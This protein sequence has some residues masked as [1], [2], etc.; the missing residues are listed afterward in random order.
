MLCVSDD[1]AAWQNIHVCW[2]WIED[3]EFGSQIN[4]AMYLIL[5][6]GH[7]CF[8]LFQGETQSNS[9]TVPTPKEKEWLKSLLD[10]ISP[11]RKTFIFNAPF[12]CI[13]VWH[14]VA[15]LLSGISPNSH[16]LTGE[17][18]TLLNACLEKK[19]DWLLPRKTTN[20]LRARNNYLC[21][22]ARSVPVV[23]E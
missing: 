13:I 17:L 6:L 3:T 19:D 18:H 1:R 10:Q 8:T 9:M 4:I 11:H 15:C 22:S 16:R 21:C 7:N 12:T 20:V 5:T 14:S 2:A 23:R